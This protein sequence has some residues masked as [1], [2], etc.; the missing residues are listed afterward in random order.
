MYIEVDLEWTYCLEMVH[1]IL[2][3]AQQVVLNHSSCM[4]DFDEWS[5][6]LPGT[7]ASKDL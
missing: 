6:Q 7:S 5:D 2:V 1:P 4:K 3:K